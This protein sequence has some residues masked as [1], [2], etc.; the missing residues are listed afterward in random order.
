MKCRIRSFLGPGLALAALLLHAG[1]SSSQA[2]TFTTNPTIDA[3]VTTGPT[4]N[5]VNNNYGGAGALS[6]SAAG[7][8]MGEL[9]S[10][11]QFSLAGAATSF[12]AAYGA[13]QWN[14]ESITLRLTASSA[15]N[16]VYNSPAAGQFR[17]SWMQN[18][19]WQE[20][21]GSPSSPGTTGITF[22][23]LQ[24]TFI[25]PNDESAG[26]FAFNGSTSGSQTYNLDLTPGLMADAQAGGNFSLRLSAA[27]TAVSGVF[28][29]R[30][31]GTVGNR[32]LLTIVAVPEPGTLTLGG[33]GLAL[34]AWI[35]RHRR[36]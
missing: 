31:F 35:G 9:Q 13:G 17:I 10:V 11:M 26:I 19:S 4:G 14:I 1:S 12:D 3:F 2:A 32:P 15:N 22:G 7:Q 24:S 6:F 36:K 8:E 5:L 25:G 33:L 23:S 20:G 16:A 29:S 27:D 34:A 18:D 30:N 21:T 28:S